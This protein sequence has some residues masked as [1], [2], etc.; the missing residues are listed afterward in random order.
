M[1]RI[2]L[3]HI[4]GGSEHHLAV[5]GEHHRLKHVGYLGDVGHLHAVGVAVENVEAQ[6]GNKSVAESVLLIEVTL[7]SAGLLIPPCAPFV[8]QK[9]HF[10]AR[11]VDSH[12]RIVALDHFLDLETLAHGP[13]EILISEFCGR[14]LAAGPSGDG[15]VVEREGIH[16]AAGVLHQHVG[17]AIVIVACARGYLIELVAVEI[18]A[19]GLIAAILVGIRFRCEVAAT[20]PALVAHAEVF[21]LPRFLTAV[22]L[23]LRCHRAIF[24]SDVF[25]PLGKL[26]YSAAAHVAAKIRFTFKQLAEIEELVSAETVVF[27]SATPVVVDHAGA[28]LAGANAV[29]PMILIGKAASGPAQYR[30]LELAQSL[31]HVVAVAFGVWYGRILANPQASVDTCA[32]VLGKLAV[33]LGGDGDLVIDL[34]EKGS[35]SGLFCCKNR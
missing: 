28:L 2:H 7:D 31:K 5:A 6:C 4:V 3:E 27:N 11:V 23:A 30:H 25:H 20:S 8:D 12:D 24:G 18:A 13:I 35:H 32:E 15:V 34:V 1:R 16:V 9:S 10:L 17:P 19:V 33:D 26:L 21:E 22:E 14:A 29:G